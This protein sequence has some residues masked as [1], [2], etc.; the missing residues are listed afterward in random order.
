MQHAGILHSSSLVSCGLL[1]TVRYKDDAVG[2]RLLR[3]WLCDGSTIRRTTSSIGVAMEIWDRRGPVPGFRRAMGNNMAG[4]HVLVLGIP[5]R[6][7]PRSHYRCHLRA[8]FLS[9]S[10]LVLFCHL[11]VWFGHFRFNI[12]TLF[13]NHKR[14]FSYYKLASAD[15]FFSQPIMT[16]KWANLSATAVSNTVHAMQA[17]ISLAGKLRG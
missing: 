14:L 7:F 12:S 1:C 10:P 11:R 15:I 9:S 8:W 3:S 6:W 2:A 17:T 16:G 5:Y 13:F 4:S